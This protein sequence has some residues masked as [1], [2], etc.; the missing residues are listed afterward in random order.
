MQNK[1]FVRYKK[2]ILKYKFHYTTK[3]K[4][5]A[6]THALIYI[7]EKSLT[8]VARRDEFHADAYNINPIF[9]SLVI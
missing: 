6:C 4:G 3:G 5:L 2:K 1:V 8:P 7:R 9:Q